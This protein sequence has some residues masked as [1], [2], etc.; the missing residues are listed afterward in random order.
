MEEDNSGNVLF[1]SILAELTT[2][3]RLFKSTE[4]NVSMKLVHAVDL[5]KKN[6]NKI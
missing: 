5:W 4:R 1:Q 3:T 6:M 2:D